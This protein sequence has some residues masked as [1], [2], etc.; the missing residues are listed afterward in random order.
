MSSLVKRAIGA[1]SLAAV[2]ALDANA[3]ANPALLAHIDSARA[4]ARGDV[5]PA[6]STVLCGDPKAVSAFLARV[7]AP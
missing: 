2:F 1:L 6:L 4:L 5:S 3:Q 7:L